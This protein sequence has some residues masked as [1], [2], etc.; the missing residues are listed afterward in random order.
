MTFA[1]RLPL[2]DRCWMTKV[3]QRSIWVV[4]IVIA[5][6]ASS[7]A[8]ETGLIRPTNLSDQA[9]ERILEQ[10][11][12]T[13]L[14]SYSATTESTK[15]F[16]STPGAAASFGWSTAADGDT[17]VVGAYGFVSYTGA[18]FVFE[19]NQGGADNWGH[20]KKITAAAG[21]ASDRFGNSV[22]ISG[23]TVVVGANGSS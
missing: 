4:M 7:A 5:M 11:D 8:A 15:I 13:D 18:A 12:R 21:A 9:W 6:V 19:R 23:D 20:T 10:L 17:V 3:G 1:I 22:S 2:D 16:A 14:K